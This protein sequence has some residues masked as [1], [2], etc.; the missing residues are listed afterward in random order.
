[1][2]FNTA[3]GTMR[4]KPTFRKCFCPQLKPTWK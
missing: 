3:Q 1:M 4:N 2:N